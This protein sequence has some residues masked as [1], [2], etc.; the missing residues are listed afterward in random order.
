VRWRSDS[1]AA[2]SSSSAL[3][4]SLALEGSTADRTS[5][6]RP[7]SRQCVTTKDQ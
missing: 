2:F 5:R 1:A 4:A 7:P 6:T 3:T